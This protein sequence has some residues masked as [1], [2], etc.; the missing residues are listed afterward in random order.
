MMCVGLGAADLVAHMK[1]K[2]S[3]GGVSN[4]FLLIFVMGIMFVESGVWDA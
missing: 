4:R 1:L 3:R 2:R